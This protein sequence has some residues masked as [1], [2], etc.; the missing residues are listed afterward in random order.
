MDQVVVVHVLG[1]EQVT[2]L[3]LAEVLRVDP[4]GPEEF[5]VCH[6]ECLPYGLCDQLGLDSSQRGKMKVNRAALL[7]DSLGPI[8][9]TEPKPSAGQWVNMGHSCLPESVS[10]LVGTF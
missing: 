5:L 8:R 2:I 9:T 7:V 10:E 3:L 4:I 1:V 6:A